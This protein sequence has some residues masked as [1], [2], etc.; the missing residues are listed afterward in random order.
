MV[1]AGKRVFLITNLKHP[2]ASRFEEGV[3]YMNIN[4]AENEV[5]V[6]NINRVMRENRSRVKTF[7][8]RHFLNQ[9][10][11][12]QKQKQ[13]MV[14]EYGYF[15]GVIT[16]IKPLKVEESILIPQN[17]IWAFEQCLK[18][19][20]RLDIDKMAVEK[21]EGGTLRNRGENGGYTGRRE[22]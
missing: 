15:M 9:N 5:N 8:K 7:G 22:V 2:T 18:C 1:K 17:M 19:L 14:Q 10:Q 12:K 11:M 4:P 16:K 3:R 21:W 13:S 20:K 6:L